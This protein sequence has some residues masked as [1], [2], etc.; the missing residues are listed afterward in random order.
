MEIIAIVVAVLIL[1]WAAG[2][3][4]SARKL[5]DM[6]NAEVTRAADE[7]KLKLVRYYANLDVD[8][9]T[10]TKAKENKEAVSSFMI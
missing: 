10:V 9:D 3:L 6:A 7:Q 5:S 8:T 2:F 4:K 1:A